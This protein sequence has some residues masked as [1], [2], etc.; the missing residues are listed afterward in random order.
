MTLSR[1]TQDRRRWQRENWLFTLATCIVIAAGL[2]LAA[3][4]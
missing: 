2:I 3:C 4:I 1:R